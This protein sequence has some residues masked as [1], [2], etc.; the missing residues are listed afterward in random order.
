MS[1]TINEVTYYRTA[2]VC[3]MIGISRSTLFR[4]LKKVV[5]TDVERRDSRGWRLFT[6]GDIDKL[7][8]EIYRVNLVKR[9]VRTR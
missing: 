7:K 5:F 2:E 1:L 9:K 3:K 8:S 4:W 6:Q